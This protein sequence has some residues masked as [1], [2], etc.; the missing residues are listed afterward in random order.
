MRRCNLLFLSI[1]SNNV[2]NVP[3]VFETFRASFLKYSIPQSLQQEDMPS[4]APLHALLVARVE[5]EHTL[6][7]QHQNQPCNLVLLV[8]AF[9][10][11]LNKLKTTNRD[12]ATAVGRNQ[13]TQPLSHFAPTA[14]ST[15]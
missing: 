10:Q 15:T 13:P 5:R 6:Q 4:I 1:L 2:I 12:H 8:A 14:E 11:A 7:H 3:S 9:H